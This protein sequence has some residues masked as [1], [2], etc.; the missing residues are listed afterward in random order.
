MPFV[1]PPA[2]EAS[3][4]LHHLQALRA[5]KRQAQIATKMLTLGK[6]DTRRQRAELKRNRATMA[7]LRRECRV[8]VSLASYT[9]IPVPD[10]NKAR[11]VEL[12]KLAGAEL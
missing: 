9:G 4:F 11:L 12:L 5:L 10:L 6:A 2:T 1:E 7:T 3:D 8:I